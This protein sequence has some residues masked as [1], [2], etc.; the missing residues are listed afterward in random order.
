MGAPLYLESRPQ[1]ELSWPSLTHPLPLCLPPP[2][3]LSWPSLNGPCPCCCS[4]ASSGFTR[5]QW[6]WELP[7]PPLSSPLRC[8]P[9]P[10][11]CH[12]L[13]SLVL[14]PRHAPGTPPGR[15]AA[16]PTS[17]DCWCGCQRS[18][19]ARPWGRRRE[20]RCLRTQQTYS[21]E[22]TGVGPA[23]T[24]KTHT[25]LPLP[26]LV[27]VH[28]CARVPVPA[29]RRIRQG[30]RRVLPSSSRGRGQRRDWGWC[31][32]GGQGQ[33]GAACAAWTCCLRGW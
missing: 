25:P 23:L 11:P 28:R 19:R 3:Q 9:A 5:M 13:P 12:T 30:L 4:T 1:A 14:P 21:S 20:P 33:G 18:R 27:Q 6:G 8:A 16:R 26:L 17:C 15:C 29:S 22:R 2:S 32:E 10:S 7:A 24:G 31:R